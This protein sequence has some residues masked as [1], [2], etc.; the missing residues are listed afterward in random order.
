MKLN[1]YFYISLVIL[2]IGMSSNIIGSFYLKNKYSSLPVLNDIFLDILPYFQVQWLYHAFTVV[3]VILMGYY[4]IKHRKE[5]IPYFLLLFG[6]SQLLRGVFIV[7]TPFGVP[8]TIYS[9]P[10]PLGME[11]FGV[12]PSG[13]TGAAFLAFLLSYG[14][15]KIIFLLFTLAIIITLLFARGHYTVDIFSALIFNYA[16]Y[17]FGKKHFKRWKLE[18]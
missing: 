10:H 12:Y 17:S 2:I 18:S 6:I 16:I 15:W 13:H 8:H 5:K 3:A 4:A 7:M 9:N 14:I 11:L 1:K